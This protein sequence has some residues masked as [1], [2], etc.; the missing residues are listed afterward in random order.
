MR[1]ARVHLGGAARRRAC[2]TLLA[3]LCSLGCGVPV[4]GLGQG[5]DGAGEEDRPADAA[6][7]GD[8]AADLGT[9]LEAGMEVSE[10]ADAALDPGTQPEIQPGQD[11]EPD[12]DSDSAASLDAD[13]APG[14]DTPLDTDTDTDTDTEMAELGGADLPPPD[15]APDA[16]PAPDAD[17]RPDA[18]PA[19]DAASDL[20]SQVDTAPDADAQADAGPPPP[21]EPEGSLCDDGELCTAVGR[22]TG[23]LC[24]PVV[25]VACSEPAPCAASA[26]TC[27]PTTGLCAAPMLPDG[28]PCVPAG[29]CAL[30]GQC[31]AGACVPSAGP[32]VGP[33]DLWFTDVT[34][35][36]EIAWNA[37]SPSTLEGGGAFVDFDGDSLPDLVLTAFGT[38][39]ESP[40]ASAWQNRGDGTFKDVSEA[41]GLAGLML[42]LTGVASADIDNDGDADLLFTSRIGSRLFRNDGAAGFTDIS[43]A[44]GVADQAWSTA[45]T[46]GDFDGDGLV[47]LYLGN[48][49]LVANYPKHTG[50]PNRLLRNLGGGVFEEVTQASGTAGKGATFAASFTDF[51]G[52]GDVDLM[53]C[54]DHGAFVEPDRLYR[55]DGPSA[56]GTVFTE[57]SASL[58]ADQAIYCMGIAA[59]DV[60]GDLRLDYYLSNLGANA[61]L[62][63]AGDDG[64]ADMASPLGV[65]LAHEPC[66]PHFLLSAW[67]SGLHD[68]D[69][70]GRLDLYVSQ[71]FVPADE[72]I[73]TAAVQPAALF[74]RAPGAT[75]FLDVASWA[76]LQATEGYGRGAAFADYDRDG[77]LDIL[78]VRANGLAHLF[79]NDGGAGHGWLGLHLVGRESHRDAIGARVV[80]RSGGVDRL[81]EAHAQGSFGSSSSPELHVGLG[82]S[83]TVERAQIRWPSGVRQELHGPAADTWHELIEPALL[84]EAVS[85]ESAAPEVG[86]RVVAHVSRRAASPGPLEATLTLRTATSNLLLASPISVAPGPGSTVVIAVAVATV[87][88]GDSL[89]I[90]V[91]I[92][93][94]AGAYDER[95]LSPADL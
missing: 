44:S 40:H 45:A 1:R 17:A 34:D 20:D 64:F 46:F 7:E 5:A 25:P 27:D 67:G 49:I 68:F 56:D 72:A 80:V 60:D 90:I 78:Q 66:P 29:E 94:P 95:V 12:S 84:L 91:R 6:S 58:G 31:D 59:G 22:C 18:P 3:V 69:G 92:E 42:P 47:D 77:D 89:E 8:A 21:C 74:T 61:L 10:P 38:S 81:R 53:V 39:A 26:P 52:D 48:Y 76:G 62:M 88:P 32:P 83:H 37:W 19:A 87:S 16:P 71:G 35:E 24:V 55:N 2:A 13:A 86:V 70:D 43:V 41:V 82:A 57:V 11:T 14:T 23:G 15:A 4:V 85:V 9:D 51:D 65:L 79:R 36:A 63:G 33:S 54:N 75:A 28:A 50:W 93:D 30:S 73:A